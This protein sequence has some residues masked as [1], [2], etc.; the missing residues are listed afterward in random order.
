MSFRHRVLPQRSAKFHRALAAWEGELFL[1][2][3]AGARKRPVLG[4][5]RMLSVTSSPGFHNLAAIPD[6]EFSRLSRLAAKISEPLMPCVFAG[7]EARMTT[8]AGTIF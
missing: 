6:H 8:C 4:R 3:F 5:Q 7:T 2:L 1:S